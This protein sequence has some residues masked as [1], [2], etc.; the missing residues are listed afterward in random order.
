MAGTGAAEDAVGSQEWELWSSEEEL[1]VE[2]T[3]F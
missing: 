2:V 1:G 3:W